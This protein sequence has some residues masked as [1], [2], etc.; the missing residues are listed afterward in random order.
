[1]PKIVL[2]SL[3]V[4]CSAVLL[5][6]AYPTSTHHS[7]PTKSAHPSA[8]IGQ[9]DVNSGDNECF[10]PCDTH[11]FPVI[12]NGLVLF[13]G[14][15]GYLQAVDRLTGAPKWEFDPKPEGGAGSLPSSILI[16]ENLAHICLYSTVYSLDL[17]TGQP[18]MSSNV[19][20]AVTSDHLLANKGVLYV[21]S[22]DHLH[23]FEIATG[24]EKWNTNVSERPPGRTTIWQADGTLYGIV[25]EVV[26][27]GLEDGTLYGID[28]QTGQ[29]KWKIATNGS[30]R[31]PVIADGVVYVGSSD[32]N[33]YTLDFQ[34]GET[35]W[36]VMTR[37]GRAHTPVVVGGSVYFACGQY[38]YAV[39]SGSGNELWECKTAGYVIGAPII[40]SELVCF[41]SHVSKSQV[42]EQDYIQALDVN[43]GKEQWRFTAPP[44][45]W[46]IAVDADG[47]Y[48]GSGPRFFG[49]DLK[50]GKEK[51]LFRLAGED[52]I[53]LLPVVV[54]G[55]AYV[56]SENQILY[57][58]DTT[59]G[60]LIWKVKA[61]VRPE[62]QPIIP[63][64]IPPRER[65][66]VA[67][68]EKIFAGR[69]RA[70]LRAI[71][72]GDMAKLSAFVHP[73]KGVRFSPYWY[74]Q[75][76]DLIFNRKQIGK[77]FASKRKYNWGRA[78]DGSGEPIRLTV[79]QYFKQWVYDRDFLNVAQIGYN[80]IVGPPAPLICN[81]EDVYPE[82]IFVSFYDPGSQS[83][84]EL[85]WA[86]LFLAFEK[87]GETWYLVGIIHN[88]WTI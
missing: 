7:A 56:V 79:R 55:V 25:D 48:F 33:L 57:A 38:L 44:L 88:V 87:R 40:T 75:P 17:S 66:S 59:T 34:T 16:A 76:E 4:L 31:F 46:G 11:L 19:E 32:G 22:G 28:T 23:A 8:V 42:D 29:Q 24:K 21:G 68:A 36:S 71:K 47:V 63:P 60:A 2:A 81:F 82:A 20:F 10:H 74:V 73:R 26:L 84:S 69:A 86:S 58:L 1:M 45:H 61:K 54:D 35:R 65:M 77:L 50:T 18:K 5:F 67:E 70:V 85:D 49:L 30:A 27:F 14:V 51:W 15:G 52:R 6:S 72:H 64:L 37:R 9:G 53:I 43:T 39:E 13:A 12:A 41:A 62:P 3:L 78:E 80:E 83:Q